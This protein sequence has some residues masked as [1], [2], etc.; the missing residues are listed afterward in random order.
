MA[1]KLQ[2]K[3]AQHLAGLPGEQHADLHLLHCTQ[4]LEAA[5]RQGDGAALLQCLSRLQLHAARLRAPQRA[6]VLGSISSSLS[7][8]VQEAACALLL[9]SVA[10]EGG[11]EA[12]SLVPALL[13][14]LLLSDEQRLKVVA[15]CCEMLAA[16]PSA[17]RDSAWAT[18]SQV[19]RRGGVG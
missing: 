15:R 17:E 13:S 12:A 4:C 5:A 16:V 3:L 1:A 14:Q 9:D 8:V 19:C 11:A 2:A 18:L 6:V 7:G 10:A